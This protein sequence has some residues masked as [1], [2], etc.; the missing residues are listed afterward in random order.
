[1]EFGKSKM[2]S[3]HDP[4][5][6]APVD[7]PNEVRLAYPRMGCLFKLTFSD[8]WLAICRHGSTIYSLPE[9][10]CAVDEE[11]RNREPPTTHFPHTVKSHLVMP[12]HPKGEFW[13]ELESIHYLTLFPPDTTLTNALP[14]TPNRPIRGDMQEATRAIKVRYMLPIPQVQAIQDTP[15][16]NKISDTADRERT[17]HP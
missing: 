9:R 11:E 16:T 5:H 14:S 4:D 7:R 13:E 2:R 12:S 17:V 15:V 6:S 10:D 8:G 3:D 1:M